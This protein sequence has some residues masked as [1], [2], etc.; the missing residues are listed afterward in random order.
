LN[1]DQAIAWLKLLGAKVPV[2]QSRTGWVL[3]EC[4]L[5]PWNHTEGKS[6]SEVFGIKI[7]DG[8][9]RCN[10]FAC[11]WHGTQSDL[12]LAMKARNKVNFQRTYP[13]GQALQLIAWIKGGIT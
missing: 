4:P 12:V 3:S 7:E 1:K 10:C 5:G 6:S 13:F 2:G 9:S 11:G 8:D